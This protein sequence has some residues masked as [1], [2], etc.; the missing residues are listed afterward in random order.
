MPCSGSGEAV[1]SAG[2]ISEAALV[3]E[4]C[5]L[6]LSVT[7]VDSGEVRSNWGPVVTEVDGAPSDMVS[8]PSLFALDFVSS[9]AKTVI[10]S[11][12]SVLGCSVLSAG[13]Y[14]LAI[15][16]CSSS[17]A[18]AAILG[19]VLGV[20]GL[21]I[22]ADRVLVRPSAL[23]GNGG[24]ES[25]TDFLEEAVALAGWAG[26]GDGSFF[27]TSLSGVLSGILTRPLSLSPSLQLAALSPKA[28]A[29]PHKPRLLGGIGGLP[30]PT[31]T[32]P[33]DLSAT[34]LEGVD[35]DNTGISSSQTF[36]I[37]PVRTK[38]QSEHVERKRVRH[39]PDAHSGY[40]VDCE[41]RVCCWDEVCEGWCGD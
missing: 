15:G 11:G 16:A 18:G 30:S 39:H 31:E 33:D 19:A 29:M 36:S 21:E 3:N 32:A 4:S 6:R 7:G 28:D 17:T 34:G 41:V 13:V 8:G 9:E 24:G 22:V 20:A 37:I 1:A 38:A 14:P 27:S 5:E 26:G 35:G 2:V 25:W 23:L 10:S 12:F 40:I